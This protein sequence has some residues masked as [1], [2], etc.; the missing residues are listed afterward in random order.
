MTITANVQFDRA[1]LERI[2]FVNMKFS[3]G[4]IFNNLNMKMA[5]F[6][7]VRLVDGK[8]IQCNM[9]GTIF[10]QCHFK[11]V[12]FENVDLRQ[13]QFND[14]SDSRNIQFSSVNLIGSNLNV[15]ND[16]LFRISNSF[17]PNGI[18]KTSFMSFG[19]NLIKNGDAEQGQCYHSYQNSTDATPQSWSRYGEVVQIFY[20]NNDWHMNMTNYTNDWRSC[21][22][23]G[24]YQD[25]NRSNSNENIIRQE[26]N[27]EQLSIL[28]N[29]RQA[30]YNASAYLGGFEDEQSSTLLKIGFKNTK[31]EIEYGIVG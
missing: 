15:T 10:E 12:I 28:I 30:K 17:L 3:A 8:F 27:V 31:S 16:N 4:T 1:N 21:F 7:G 19:R 26:I 14:F 20:K 18:F 29:S 5:K 25:S 23:F 9:I 11:D 6:S 2:T 22:F 13:S 24:G